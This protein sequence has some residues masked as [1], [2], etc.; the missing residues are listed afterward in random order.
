MSN[1]M[2][3]VTLVL[4]GCGAGADEATPSTSSG[5]D[6]LATEPEDPEPVSQLTA[7]QRGVLEPELR[8]YGSG[9]TL[10]DIEKVYTVQATAIRGG[11]DLL[12]VARGHSG[13]FSAPRILIGGT[14]SGSQLNLPEGPELTEAQRDQAD[15][16]LRAARELWLIGSG[17]ECQRLDLREGLTS[18]V[19]Q[20]TLQTRLH[21]GRA[22]LMV[23]HERGD[24]FVVVVDLE[25]RKIL[26]ASHRSMPPILGRGMLDMDEVTFIDQALRRHGDFGVYGNVTRGLRALVEDS[27][28]RITRAEDHYGIGIYTHDGHGHDF[29]FSIDRTTGV[30]ENMAAGHS[31]SVDEM[32]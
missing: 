20:G 6:S 9:W 4:L 8:R 1:R 28:V 7:E 22:V 19:G 29:S 27:R 13:L 26:E 12:F 11:Y 21:D 24:P 15:S 17:D 2:L 32:E 10:S 18:I 30:I 25:E 31:V 23:T 16:A 14:F 5:G 3:V